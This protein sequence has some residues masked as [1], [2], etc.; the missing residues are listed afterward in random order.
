[1]AEPRVIIAYSLN[2]LGEKAEIIAAVGNDFGR[3]EYWLKKQ[4][5]PLEGL[6]VFDEVPTAGAYI[7]NDAS[8]NMINAFHPGAMNFEAPI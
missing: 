1:M 5:L 6:R 8:G 2:L 7:I 3:Y 4:G